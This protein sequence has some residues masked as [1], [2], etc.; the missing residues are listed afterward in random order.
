L[1]TLQGVSDSGASN[2]Q[3]QLDAFPDTGTAQLELISVGN[4]E[5]IANTARTDMFS[6]TPFRIGTGIS[7]FTNGITISVAVGV[8]VT[9]PLRLTSSLNYGKSTLS[10]GS[11]TVSNTLVTSS[12]VI[13][14]TCQ[15]AGGTQGF[16]SIGTIVPGVSFQILS[17]SGTDVS[18]IGWTIL[19]N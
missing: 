8:E 10:S 16:L 2:C 3:L 1:V 12:S 7:G 14:L 19:N 5:L 4:F 17:S 11:V 15:A 18:T 13:Q 6:N 9:G